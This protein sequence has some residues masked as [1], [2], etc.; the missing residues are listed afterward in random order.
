MDEATS[1]ASLIKPH[2]TLTVRPDEIPMDSEALGPMEW[3]VNPFLH[4]PSFLCLNN[5]IVYFKNYEGLF[6]YFPINFKDKFT[7]LNKTAD[8]VL[9]WQDHYDE[10]ENL[11]REGYRLI[12]SSKF[13][14]LFKKYFAFDK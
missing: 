10:I 3:V 12:H 2:S 14:K 1:A 4:L 7:Y 13:N 11:K 9:V 8:Y 5:D 6:N